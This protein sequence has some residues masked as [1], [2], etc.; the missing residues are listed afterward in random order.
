[1]CHCCLV[2]VSPSRVLV[3]QSLQLKKLQIIER[4]NFCVILLL[5]NLNKELFQNP[6]NNSAWEYVLIHANKLRRVV[7]HCKSIIEIR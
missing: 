3:I 1:M 2:S 4:D 7:V 6:K 5:C